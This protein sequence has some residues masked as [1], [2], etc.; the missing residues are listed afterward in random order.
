MAD[1]RPRVLLIAESANPEWVSVPLVGWSTFRALSKVA[2]VH[3][4]TQVRNGEA[5]RRVSLDE[6]DYTLIDSEAVARLAWRLGRIFR[7]GAG[8]GWTTVMA[9]NAVAYY[10]FEHLVWKRFRRAIVAGEY[11][12]VHR[13]TPLSPTVP[14]RLARRCRRCGVP[15]LLGPLNGGLPWPP[16]FDR[17]RRKEKE[18][19]SYMRG[20][21]RLLPGVR[22][23][24]KNAAA[25]IVGSLNTLEQIP[26]GYREKCVYI[27]ENAID[28]KKFSGGP[29]GPAGSPLRVIFVGRLVPYK[30]ADMVL[31]AAAPLLRAGV[32]TL[33]IVGDGPERRYLEEAARKEAVYERV[34]WAGWIEHSEVRKHL[35]CS[36]ILAFPSVR[37]FGGGVVLEAMAAG[38]VPVVVNYGGPAELV[39][40]STGSL[41]ELSSRERMVLDLRICLD[42]AIADPSSVGRKSLLAR[43]RVRDYFTWEAKADQVAEVYRWVLGERRSKP[44]WGAPFGKVEG[45]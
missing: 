35:E 18:W 27:P 39:T 26:E 17:A 8:K 19:L 9:F 38:V 20:L 43:Q 32:M 12:L 25:I 22:S 5:I 4:V 10:Y 42:R 15:F 6:A 31:E 40:E 23:T 34:T 30:G 29:R 3:L 36:D 7:G 24:R 14:S 16:G 2:D 28:L 41:I 45:A 11:D 1:R 37:E 13:V 44:G 21:Y 33:T